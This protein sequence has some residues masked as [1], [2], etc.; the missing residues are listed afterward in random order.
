M[1]GDQQRCLDAGCDNYLPKPVSVAA[2]VTVFKRYGDAVA[3][4]KP[5]FSSF[6]P[7]LVTKEST[8]TALSS[9][10]VA[11]AVPVTSLSPQAVVEVSPLSVV[12]PVE[13]A[14]PAAA[15]PAVVP[16]TKVTVVDAPA[17]TTQPEP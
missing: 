16:I 17:V 4:G 13:P 10:L 6:K 2:V 14:P 15:S 12:M 3:S 11:E 7:A 8:V 1:K 9:Q 5:I